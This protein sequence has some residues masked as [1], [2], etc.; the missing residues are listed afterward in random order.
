MPYRLS[1][2][3]LRFFD[4]N[5]FVVLAGVLTREEL[6]ALRGRV[7]LVM[8]SSNARQRDPVP[9]DAYAE[10][11]HR[12]MN[13]REHDQ[14]VEAFVLDAYLAEIACRLLDVGG[15]RVSHDTAFFKNG[16]AP[17]T[18][19]HADQYHWPLSSDRTVTAWIPLEDIP[20]SKGPIAFFTK[21]HRVPQDERERLAD[22]AQEDLEEYMKSSGYQLYSQPFSLGEISFHLGWTFH[23]ALAN[24]SKNMRKVFSIVYVDEN[25]RL[26]EPRGGAPLDAV[27]MNWC[28]GC[29]VGDFL[30]SPLNPV[31]FQSS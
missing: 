9:R 29:K 31:V 16:G 27:S 5:G 19:I 25:T 20:F 26:T 10:A 23:C 14:L 12:L 8:S 17:K 11:Y 24:E 30:S 13:V 7:S 15:V 2:E 22:A 4:D 21:S 3:C 18:P 6:G 28:P 1:S